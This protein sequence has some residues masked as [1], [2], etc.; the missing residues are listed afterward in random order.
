MQEIKVVDM[1]GYYLFLTGNVIVKMKSPSHCPYLSSDVTLIYTH[2][3]PEG[4]GEGT[5]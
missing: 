5:G 4:T 1:D 3:L 2:C